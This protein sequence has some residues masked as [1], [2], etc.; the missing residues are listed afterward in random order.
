MMIIM[1]M[2]TEWYNK[3]KEVKIYDP[4]SGITCLF[5]GTPM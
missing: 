3:L 2:K 4:E 1:I 5:L